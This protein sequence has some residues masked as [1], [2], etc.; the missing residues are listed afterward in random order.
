MQDVTSQSSPGALC[1]MAL[2]PPG[3]LFPCGQIQDVGML[4]C[5]EEAEPLMTQS[6]ALVPN[7]A[8]LFQGVLES[9]GRAFGGW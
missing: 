9:Q 8:T 7:S 3:S 6:G 5:V 1:G 4:H 2:L